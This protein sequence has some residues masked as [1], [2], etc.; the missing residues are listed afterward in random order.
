MKIKYLHTFKTIFA[1]IALSLVL[2]VPTAL[3]ISD[4]AGGVDAQSNGGSTQSLT[5]QG[6]SN[7]G[8]NQSPAEQSQSNG[9]GKLDENKRKICEQSSNRIKNTFTKMNQ[10]GQGQLNLFDNIYEKVQRFA[11]SNKINV[12]NYEQLLSNVNEIRESAQL[13]IQNSANTSSQ[14]GCDKDDP[15]GVAGQYKVQVESQVNTLKDYRVAL[16]DLISAVQLA[17]QTTSEGGISQ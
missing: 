11:D 17:P 16:K 1:G 14:F 7:G 12:E 2:T 9:I 3:A 15:K 10:L 8:S 13:A 5:E 4:K 6:Q